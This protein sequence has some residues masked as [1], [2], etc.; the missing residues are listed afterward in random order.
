MKI[1]LILLLFICFFFSLIN[2]YSFDNG[3]NE[4][5]VSLGY[6]GVGIKADTEIADF[7]VNGKIINIMYQSN[8]GVG[9]SFSPFIFF[10][11]VENTDNFSLSFINIS[12]FFNTLTLISRN[13]ILGPFF[14]VNTL[15]YNDTSFIFR[16]GVVFSLRN[17][18]GYYFKN[19]IL[20][21]DIF[22]V[23]FGYKYDI[24][25]NNYLYSHV[26]LDLLTAIWYVG[27][28]K[29]SEANKYRDF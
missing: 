13:F 27:L 29:E 10:T 20:S 19:N 14:T 26:C 16:S 4:I 1:K 2:L 15:N 7:Y 8:N 21:T 28:G 17:L 3:D 9:I 18:P 6:L 11:S 22:S 24:M 23:E 5:G 25:G 12:L